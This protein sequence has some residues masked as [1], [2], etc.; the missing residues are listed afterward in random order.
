VHI[1]TEICNS[2]TRILD[3]FQP[4]LVSVFVISFVFVKKVFVSAGFYHIIDL[5]FI[6]FT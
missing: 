4:F 5:L 3:S 1:H 2:Q 6:F